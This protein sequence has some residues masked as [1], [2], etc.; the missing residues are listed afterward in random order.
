MEQQPADPRP[1]RELLERPPVTNEIVMAPYEDQETEIAALLSGEVDYIYPQFTDT[2][3]ASFEGQA[4]IEP[5]IEV[6]SDYEGFYFQSNEG[7]FA[8]PVFRQAFAMSIDRDA[9][10]QQIYAPI[11]EAAGLE[12]TLLQ[13]GPIVPGPFCFDSFTENA[14]DPEGAAALLEGDG[15]TQNGQGMWEKDGQVPEIRWMINAGNLRR[16]N[17]QAFLILL[18]GSRLQRRAGQRLGRGG[19]PAAAAGDGL[20]HGDVHLHGRSGPAV[21]HDELHLRPDPHG[22]ARLQGQNSTGWCNEEASAALEEADVTVDENARAELIHTA[23]DL[24]AEDWAMLPLVQYPRSG[25]WRTRR[26]P[27]SRSDRELPGLQQR[28][29]V[30]G[31]RRRWPH[32]DRCR[33]VAGLPQPVA[34]APTRPGTSGRPRSR[35]SRTCG[36][37]RPIRRFVTTDLV[38]GEPVVETQ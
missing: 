2:L 24:M 28:P 13:C 15:W 6:G 29:R 19:L 36:T 9:V 17:T 34:G 30:G 7:P 27:V 3:S 32:R 25:F 16:E 31:R 10:L 38:V 5:G 23:L 14:Y 18:A 22:R 33:A 26:S 20:R 4:E 8:D 37:R 1:E 35:C 21:P 12:T 11:Y